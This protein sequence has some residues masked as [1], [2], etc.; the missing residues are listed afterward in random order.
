MNQD[1]KTFQNDTSNSK[2]YCIYH[3]FAGLEYYAGGPV[4][5]YVKS[6]D[7][8]DSAYEYIDEFMK[9][10]YSYCVEWYR[11]IKS[12]SSSYWEVI[13]LH[14]DIHGSDNY[15]YRDDRLECL[16]CKFSKCK[17]YEHETTHDKKN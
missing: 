8:L 10:G 14:G 15:E 9:N 13:S 7:N 2:T 4:A 11:L 3:L 12:C 6:F 17:N 1:D 16:N 5:D